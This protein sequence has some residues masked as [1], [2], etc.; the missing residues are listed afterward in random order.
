MPM[1]LKVNGASD[2]EL[3]FKKTQQQKQEHLKLKGISQSAIGQGAGV[4]F[5]SETMIRL[6]SLAYLSSE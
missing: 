5:Y 4:C 6:L 2:N 1:V 3:L